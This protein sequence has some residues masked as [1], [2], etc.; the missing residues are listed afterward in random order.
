MELPKDPVIE[1]YK[2]EIDITMVRESLKRTPQERI[3]A[4]IAMHRFADEVKRAREQ[5]K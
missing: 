1:T 5:K 4:L 3:D 2:K